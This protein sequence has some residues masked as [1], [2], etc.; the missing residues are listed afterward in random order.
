VCL[1]LVVVAFAQRVGQTTFDTKFDL[2]ADPV[3]ALG[4]SLHLWDAGQD[5]GSLQNQAYGYLFP[6]G[7]FFALVHLV[8]VPDWI[9]QRLWSALVLLIAYDGARRL[10]RAL[11]IGHT[12]TP[13]VVGLA[14]ATA[15]RIIGLSGVLSAEILPSAVLPWVCLPLVLGLTGRLS[16][17]RA[18]LLAGVAVLG[19]GGVNAVEDLATFPL[20]FLLVA[21]GLR[22]AAG[23]RLAGWWAAATAAASLW[24]MVPLVLLG[25]Y[26]P[27]FLDFV[28]SAA[29]TTRTTGWS[30]DLRGAEHWLNYLYLGGAPWWTA[31]HALSVVPALV[32]AA[33]AVS[34]LGLL[35]LTHRALPFR[36]PLLLSV[37]VG[38]VCLAAGHGG[39]AG[40]P[41]AGRIRSLLDGP[42]APFR[43]VHKV[44]PL[45]R[46][47]LALGFGVSCLVVAAVVR[48][49]AR[50]RSTVA[51][52]GAGRARHVGTAVALVALSGAVAPAFADDLR[53]PGWTQVPA[54]WTQ[55]AAWLK[56][57]GPGTTLVVP[58]AGM[59]QQ[60]WGWTVDEPIQG[61][62]AGAWATRSQVPLV[63]ATTI[64]MLDGLDAR[65]EDGGSSGLAASLA[66]AGITRVLLRNDVDPV[67]GDVADPARVAAALAESPG[68]VPVRAFGRTDIGLPLIE[69]YRVAA[70]PTSP[71]LV[72]DPAELPVVT[73]GPEDVLTARDAGLL[74][75]SQHAE[76]GMPRPGTAPDIVGDGYRR[77]ERQYGRLHGAVSQVM[78]ADEPTRLDRSVTDYPGVPGVPRVVA[79]YDA[80]TDVLASTSAG[81]VDGLAPTRPELGPAS[82]V[83]GD[84]ATYWATAPLTEPVGQWLQLDLRRSRPIHRVTVDALVDP[85]LG[86]PVR[87]VVIAAGGRTRSVAVDPI[88]GLAAVDLGG[89][90]ADRIRVTI[91]SV[92]PHSEGASTGLRD[93]V[94]AGLDQ[95]R[96][97]VLPD[98]GADGHTSFVFSADPPV[99]AC[100]HTVLGPSCDISQ[101]RS[102]SEQAAMSR[103]FTLHGSGTWT[104]VG[105]V[106]SLPGTGSAQALEPLGGAIAASSAS[107]YGGDPSVSAMFAV[108]GQAD[109]SWLAAA[110]DRNPTITLSWHQERRISRIVIR[111]SLVA[112][113]TP[114][115]VDLVAADGARR[116]V[117]LGDG[118]LGYFAPLRT[119]RVTLTFH[120]AAGGADPGRPPVGIGEIVITGI[121]DLMHP[122]AAGWSF[123]GLCGLGPTVHLDG[124]V[125]RTRVSGTLGDI[126]AG[127]ALTWSLCGPDSTITLTAGE[128]RL[129][130]ASTDTYA[131]TRIALRS[132]AGA[133]VSG[134]P[135]TRTLSSDLRS[136]SMS[137]RVGP[138]RRSVLVLGQNVNAGWQA[139]F[140]GHTLAAQVVDGWQQGFVVPAGAG[141][142]LT[143]RFAPAGEYRDGLLVGAAGALILLLL[144]L[145]DL[146]RPAPVRAAQERAD[147]T[148]GWWR[149]PGRIAVFLGALVVAGPVMAGSL[150]VGFAAVRVL[151][152]RA[153]AVTACLLVLASGVLA[154]LI[155]G[156]GSGEPGAAADVVGAIGVGLFAATLSRTG[157]RGDLDVIG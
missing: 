57:D 37:L 33:A 8:A 61:L 112:A 151:E 56:A 45:I 146:V 40:T 100:L 29:T 131:P 43:N 26:S 103:V 123:S 34:A 85:Y 21:S 30:N 111:P 156:L 3:A 78:T 105:Q 4:R 81:Y 130:V 20:P 42:L 107:V 27:P 90:R 72:S 120:A 154:V 66:A 134:V 122:I 31:A 70:A 108:D 23:R 58:A 89:V 53:H 1:L 133:P 148:R 50:L 80:L 39:P 52:V 124:R 101:A 24:W 59:G 149:H 75:P 54:A 110:G 91:T 119:D 55:A 38:L 106:A 5:F 84:P 117:S 143:V 93:V 99:R 121:E 138:G 87:R 35:G 88:T 115:S 36:V 141:G 142:V 32:L 132:S 155:G 51:T 15:P 46:L 63:P 7:S 69:V 48:R 118:G 127:R 153:L 129:D 157:A 116:T 65:F 49:S 109:T 76:V 92:G 25:R 95:R 10:A 71:V 136:S 41:W 16:P 98:T 135:V 125:Y 22:S 140:A 113:T 152:R 96:A 150:A 147:R 104:F 62:D 94:V 114:G 97:L 145:L 68:L 60:T 77:I 44:D 82:A 12:A 17:R 74:A 9:A 126:V 83:D 18:G 67:G 47:P 139:T 86:A 2:T 64:R 128:H 14:Y 79:A 137:F 6:Q 144:L 102:G 19:M 73:G 11:G 13:V 28:E